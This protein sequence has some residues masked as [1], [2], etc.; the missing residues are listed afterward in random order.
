[1]SSCIFNF[2]PDFIMYKSACTKIIP[3]KKLQIPIRIN[4]TP[5][6]QNTT[7]HQKKHP[8]PVFH[9]FFYSTK[10]LTFK[11]SKSTQFSIMNNRIPVKKKKNNP[12]IHH[13]L[14]IIILF[15]N[16]IKKDQEST[17]KVIS[18]PAPHCAIHPRLKEVNVFLHTKINYVRFINWWVWILMRIYSK[19]LFGTIH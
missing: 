18:L 4:P 8:I 7:R 3:K 1:M 9:N 5:T 16:Y 13:A 19:K 11:T 17:W 6:R 14:Y 15:K 2:F 12:I 10:T